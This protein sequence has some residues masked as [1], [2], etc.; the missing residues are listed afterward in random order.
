MKITISLLSQWWDRHFY[1]VYEKP[2][3]VSD[4]EL[5]RVY[6]Q[7]MKFL[8]SHYAEFG[9]GE[10]DPKPDPAW[11]GIIMKWC[12]DFIPFLLGTPMYC[13]PTGYWQAMPQKKE[14]I[15]K[16]EP[17]DIRNTSMGE[18]VLRRKKTLENKYG[19]AQIAQ[20]VEGSVNAAVRIQGEEFYCE[21]IQDPPFVRNLL[22]VITETVI[23]TY[24]FFAD[25]FDLQEVFLANCSNAHIGP[26]LYEEYGLDN[27]IRIAGAAKKLIPSERFVYFHHCDGIS[28][29]FID[30]YAQV[31]HISKIDSSYKADLGRLRRAFPDSCLSIFF[32]PKWVMLTRDERRKTIL[33]SILAGMDEMIL[34][35]LDPTA[36]PEALKVVFEDIRAACGE[37]G[38][39]PEFSIVPFSEDEY[40]WSTPVYQGSGIFRITDPS[41]LLIP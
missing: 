15:K 1:S 37:A 4:D 6:L 8:Y 10:E 31:P 17:V 40:D 7:R 13:I 9:L 36:S 38:A 34:A 30:L 25:H 5:E 18:W 26:S 24:E 39:V 19:S 33:D 32:N 21:L 3:R 2:D 41:C 35:N 27:D 11:L 23:K 22:D 29:A 20:L 28:D 16:L 12:V 14:E